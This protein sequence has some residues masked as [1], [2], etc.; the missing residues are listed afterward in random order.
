MNV[1][2]LKKSVIRLPRKTSQLFSVLILGLILMGS[3]TSGVHAEQAK[4]DDVSVMATV[5]INSASANDIAEGLLGV[6][7]KKAEAIVEYREQNGPFTD[8]EQL[9]GVKGIGEATLRKNSR[10]ITLK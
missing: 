1:S 7:I 5:N 4:T 9:L 2:H 10:V 3:P 8:K 6:G